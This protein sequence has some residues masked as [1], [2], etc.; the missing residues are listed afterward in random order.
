MKNI[1]TLQNTI[2][3][4]IGLLENNPSP[5]KYGIDSKRAIYEATKQAREAIDQ[6][7]NIQNDLRRKITCHSHLWENIHNQNTFPK[8]V[9]P[10]VFEN[11]KTIPVYS[12]SWGK[13]FDGKEDLNLKA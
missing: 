4:L 10:P 13:E 1:E 9:Q 6:L 11:T 8:I 7:E 3:S 2:S 12:K 5:E